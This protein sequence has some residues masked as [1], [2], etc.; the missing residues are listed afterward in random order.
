MILAYPSSLNAIPPVGHLRMHI[1]HPMHKSSSI[2]TSLFS[3]RLMESVGQT[4]LSL[5][6]GMLSMILKFIS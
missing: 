5:L 1:V 2:V 6:K 3:L 4:L